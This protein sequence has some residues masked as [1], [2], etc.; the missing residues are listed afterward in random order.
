MLKKWV[1]HLYRHST[2][3]TIFSS[4]LIILL[5]LSSR[6]PPIDGQLSGLNIENTK[7]YKAGEQVATFF[8]L[9]EIIEVEI[10]P[11]NTRTNNIFNS[12]LEIEQN[13]KDS[14]PHI[15]VVSIHQAKTL[16]QNELDS[17]Y[18]IWPLLEKASKI[19]I[20]QDLISNDLKSFLLVVKLTSKENFD[21]AK[22][23]RIIHMHYNGIKDIKCMS[24][25]HVEAQIATSLRQDVL[26]ISAIIILLLSLFIIYTYR[27]FAALLYAVIILLISIT[28]TFFLF[29]ILDIPINLI[30]A[31]A[32]PIILVLSLADAIHLLTG[33]YNATEINPEQRIIGTMKSYIVPSF[34]TS[35]TTT[36]A[37]F[38]FLL[39]DA[40]NVQNF[41]LIVSFSVM[42]SFFL[43]YMISPFLLKK[44]KPKSIP[45]SKLKSLLAY[46]KQK[47]KPISYILILIALLSIP[48]IGQLSFDT[49]FDSFIPKNTAISENRKE[50]SDKF[51]SQL[52]IS[53]LIE[54]D[55]VSNS[56]NSKAIEK[57]ILSIVNKL[58]NLEAIGTIKSIQDQ[59]KFKTRFGPFANA[60]RL[61]SKNNPYRSE[62]KQTYRVEV[63]LK[64]IND[65]QSVNNQ[66]IEILNQYNN[67]YHTTIYCKALL[68]D[69]VNQGVAK[70]LFYSLLFSFI[71]IF[72]C[73]LILTKSFLITL[74]SIF[75]NIIPLSFIAIIFYFAKLDLNILTAITTVV[76]LGIIVDDTLHV[77]Y[78]KQILK[79]DD[80]ELGEGILTTSI[81]LV[82]GF[83]IFLLSSFEPCQTFGYVS[84]LVFLSTMIA[85]LTLLPFLLDLG[86][87]L[88]SS[89]LRN[90][91]KKH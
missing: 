86:S 3:Y 28:P 55:S 83:L 52:A 78:R 68:I 23:N 74:I 70:S 9:S 6:I 85:D 26:L 56:K 36:I 53:I 50:L 29:T 81:I 57:D 38:S 11:E 79:K 87:K 19:P 67:E 89:P 7:Y 76:C 44:L 21:L 41:G 69:E 43:T 31:L 73:F 71:F 12:L 65:L 20:I 80:D 34:L 64:N 88:P 18:S 2:K 54:K 48:L 25:F 63:R 33:Y 15:E 35:L 45:K 46:F 51:N 60:I 58:K 84:A 32:I 27:N 16:F 61:P 17:N 30:T 10:I 82:I 42:P 40:E 8:K 90:T 4:I 13:L 66:I 47:R 22:F 72:L 75:A 24:T 14:L 77:I 5:G 37:F 91:D 62:D 39:N 1:D 59:I 49:D